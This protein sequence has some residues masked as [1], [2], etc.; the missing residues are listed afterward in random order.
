MRGIPLFNFPAFDEAKAKLEALGF[1]VISP[2]DLDRQVGF[3]ENSTLPADDN[4]AFIRSAME[5]D[6][7]AICHCTHI[8]LLEGWNLS[9][10]CRPEI[11]LAHTLGLT[12]MYCAG[13]LAGEIPG[14]DVIAV[15]GSYL[16]MAGKP[17]A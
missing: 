13:N 11:V 4:G 8:A 15:V 14:D 1:R 10:G 17:T 2:A 16:I 3:N 5:R 9:K 7:T 12:F 6:L